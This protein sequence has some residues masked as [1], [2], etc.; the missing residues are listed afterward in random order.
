MVAGSIPNNTTAGIFCWFFHGI[1]MQGSHNRCCSFTLYD[2]AGRKPRSPRS[3]V[4]SPFTH[5]SAK[6]LFAAE[7]TL[8]GRAG[9]LALAAGDKL[10][11]LEDLR[12]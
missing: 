3:T 8:G 12:G 11:D 9:K 1:H 2:W 10:L 6:P 4:S 5:P 7:A